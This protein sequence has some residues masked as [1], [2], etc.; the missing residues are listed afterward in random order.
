MT[1]GFAPPVTGMVGVNVDGAPMYAT[2]LTVPRKAEFSARFS[3][4]EGVHKVEVLLADFSGKTVSTG[5]ARQD[6]RPGVT[7][8]IVVTLDG[9]P[10]SVQIVFTDPLVGKAAKVPISVVAHDVDNEPID[11]GNYLTPFRVAEKGWSSHVKFGSLVFTKPGDVATVTYDGKLMTSPILLSVVNPPPYSTNGTVS[12]IGNPYRIYP[13]KGAV[14]D[15]AF[16]PHNSI[17]YAECEANENCDIGRIQPDGTPKVVGKTEYVDR[18]VEGPDGNMWF[19]EGEQG[20]ELAG[21]TIGRVTPDGKVTQFTIRTLRERTAFGTF[22]ILAARDKSAIWFTEIDRIGRITMDGKSTEY[23]LNVGHVGP[24]RSQFFVEGPNGVFYFDGAELSVF[25]FNSANS[26]TTTAPNVAGPLVWTKE[27]LLL[28]AGTGSALL[29]SDGVTTT[30][31]SGTPYNFIYAGSGDLLVGT[32]TIYS[33]TS[34]TPAT[35]VNTLRSRSLRSIAYPSAS[36]ATYALSNIGGGDGPYFLAIALGS[37][38]S[39]LHSLAVFTY[40]P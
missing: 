32:Q 16:G 20:R 28:R 26:S 37:P 22:S 18:L 12:F 38:S 34:S 13:T 29:N 39:P 40:D 2:T 1:T 25:G 35:T 8:P 23:A 9:I 6:F 4:P 31:V 33:S 5:T 14:F 27:G 17:W 10:G 11:A 21:P 30:P 15:V 36:S 19:T 3:V 24:I 7:T